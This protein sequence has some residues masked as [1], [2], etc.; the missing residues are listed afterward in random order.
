MDEET[1]SVYEPKGK[2]NKRQ[3]LTA[4]KIW[5]DYENALSYQ[6][7]MGFSEKYPEYEKFKNG[8]QWPAATERTR[9]LPRPV[10]N[11]IRMFVSNKKS[12]V[13]SQNVKLIFSPC[14]VYDDETSI[15][16]I[17]GAED[18]TDFAAN[19]WAELKQ[20]TLNDYM[21][22][23]AVT[24]GTGI[25]HYY[26]DSTVTG[27]EQ[28]PY[29][30]AL[31]GEAIDPLNIFFANPQQ[32]DVQKQEWIIVAGRED[33]I[34]LR[35]EAE[36]NG[37]PAKDIELI[38]GDK[39][40]E[41]TGYDAARKEQQ[42]NEKTWVLTRYYRDSTDGVCVCR[43]TQN[44]I[45][46]PG[47][48]ITP[49]TLTEREERYYEA[50]GEPINR[51][52]I[53]RYPIAVFP[54]YTAKKC[55]FG[56]GEVEGLI[57]NQKAIN[58]NMAMMLLSVQDNAWPK[59]VAKPGAL[60]QQITNKPGEILTDYYTSGDGVKY[61][62]PPNFNYMSI[63]LVDK[64]FELSRTTSGVTEVTTGESLGANMAA[65]AIIALQNQARV[66]IDNIQKRFYRC[67]QDVGL[68]WEEFFKTYYNTPRSIAKEDVNGGIYSKRFI[69]ENYSNVEFSLK[70]D[71]SAS[72]TYS[73]SLA[74]TYLDKMYDKG[75]ITADMY[76]ELAPN[77]VVPYREKLKQLRRQ[78]IQQGVN[79]Y[80]PVNTGEVQSM[81][82]GDMLNLG[83]YE[84]EMP[85]LQYGGNNSQDFY[86]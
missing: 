73:E 63:N 83:G 24:F 25:L 13:L 69:G 23:D 79:N 32:T 27:G 21:V 49:N 16:A 55:I 51:H 47:K 36:A 12:N 58:F 46:T 1:N 77:S 60:K 18:Y 35:K 20:D 9:A 38:Q 11:I 71:I 37:L 10:F 80:A 85:A 61:M 28:T 81:P 62:Q 67:L 52:I 50:L 30:G 84:N 86:G 17:E 34:K 39:S 70:V 53:K 48:S 2:N 14:E 56:L 76:I 68:I 7:M 5:R 74:L 45:I 31:R 3:T 54:W 64:V 8:D 65:S 42:G 19:L 82:T 43:S 22:D 41:A 78:M 57:P 4:D 33:V 40:T 75:D 72:S 44:V 26:W 15:V 59:I 29:I 66:P 6:R